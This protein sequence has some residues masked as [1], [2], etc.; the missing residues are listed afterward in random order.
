MYM[1]LFR[2]DIFYMIKNRLNEESYNNQGYKMKIIKYN[3]SED[4][5]VRFL[6]M[7]NSFI[8]SIV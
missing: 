4:I 1:N 3:N 6:E 5:T 8:G 2:K 7:R